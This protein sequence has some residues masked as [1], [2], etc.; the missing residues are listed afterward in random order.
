MSEKT[1]P[2]AQKGVSRR[3]FALGAVIAGAASVAPATAR[4]VVQNRRRNGIVTKPIPATGEQ[5]PAIGLGTFETFDLLPGE[6]VTAQKKVL[7]TFAAAGGTVI[8]TSPLYGSSETVVG[9]IASALNIGDDV[10]M[11]TKIWDTGR[12]LGDESDY[13]RQFTQSRLRLWRDKIDCGLVHSLTNGPTALRFLRR[14]KDDGGVRYVGATHFMYPFYDAL[15]QA[16][17]SGALDF[18]QLNYSVFSRRAEERLLPRAADNGVAVMAN[19]PFEKARLFPVVKG[20]R[21]PDW[22]RD[23]G[24]A[25]WSQVFLK[26]V[27]SHPAVTC[28]V[29]ATSN[30]DHA[31]ENME[32]LRGPL[33]D[34]ALREEI[35]RFLSSL[36][37]F[38]AVL[39][40]PP[41]PGKSYGGL[42]EF[43][44]RQP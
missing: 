9:N 44:L 6:D 25:A 32:A 5:I 8:D 35:I 33:P 34:Q 21:L 3:D 19:M 2:H 1:K 39:S 20:V 16:I 37:G 30:P 28:V 22:A 17:G 29:P 10:F 13:D 26:Y 14:L 42:V 43:P 7:E 24:C 27:I 4:S 23:I 38:D 40:M 12:W 11:A 15:D 31:K 18:V 36:D 41:Y